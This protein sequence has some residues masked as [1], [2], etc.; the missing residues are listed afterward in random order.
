M[1]PTGI[2]HI[3]AIGG[4]AQRNLDFYRDDLGMR[5][6]KRTVNFDDP[7]TY[8]LY[9]ADEA[10]TPGSVLT[11]FP[12]A[13]AAPG[14]V[15]SGE[16]TCTALSVPA[17]SFDHW[18][19]RLVERAVAVTQGERFGADTLRFSDPDGM[20]FELVEQA[21]SGAGD[22]EEWRPRGFHGATLSVAHPEGT[23]RVLTELL[24]Y[25][26]MAEE[27]G[28]VRFRADGVSIGASIDVEPVPGSPRGRL[29]RGSVHHI[30]FRVPNDEAHLEMREAVESF[31]IPVTEVKDRNYFRSIYFREPGGILFEVATDP[32]G[33][34][35]DEAPDSLGTHLRLPP[36]F[37][38]DRESIERRLPPLD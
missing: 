5:L 27:D 8:H 16:V 18:R 20:Q 25:R 34:T 33:F 3:T 37:E 12:W 9:Y 1:H 32:P 28:R 17:G 15:G 29:G 6:V 22:E 38:Q 24:G 4:P 36:W 31:G 19:S 2:H 10:G 21:G 11:F 7:G 14:R 23:S 13:H 26:E 35:V 30:A